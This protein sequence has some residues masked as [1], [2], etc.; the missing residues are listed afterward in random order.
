MAEHSR[1]LWGWV[2][3]R[4]AARACLLGI[5]AKE[6]AWKGHEPFFIVAPNTVMDMLSEDLSSTVYPEVNDIRKPWKGNSSF[7]DCSKAEKILGWREEE[8]GP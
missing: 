4:A 8:V 3:Q 2:S 1:D 6:E 7:F 5:T